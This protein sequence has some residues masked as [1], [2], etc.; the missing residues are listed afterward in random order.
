M[1]DYYYTV[2]NEV[3]TTLEHHALKLKICGMKLNTVQV[4]ALH[5]DYLGFIFWEKSKRNYTRTLDEIPHNIKKVGVFVDASIIEI[6]E[7]IKNYGLVA[8]Q[9]H[10]DESPEFCRAL[11]KKSKN[12]QL[13]KVFSVLD[14]FD[15]SKLAPYEE[16][17]DFYL[18]DTK[19]KLPGG[20]GYTFDWSILNN[21]ASTKPYFLSGGIGLEELKK[22]KA[23]LKMPTS[24][25]CHAIDVNSK[26]ELEPGLKDIDKLKKL[27]SVLSAKY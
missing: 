23:F 8:V 15:F 21:Y 6:I 5:P 10:G 19:G 18:F 3:P 25:Y 2:K 11:K 22:L 20:N 13:I 16:V 24:K 1:A 12:I 26:F 17:C 7:K 9:L 4:A 27:K 14:E